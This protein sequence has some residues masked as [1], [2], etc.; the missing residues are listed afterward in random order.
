MKENN[1]KQ[2]YESIMASIAKEV[3][4]ALNEAK[5]DNFNNGEAYR[6]LKFY[7][8]KAIKMTLGETSAELAETK[9]QLLMRLK[10]G[11]SLKTVN[12]TMCYIN[13]NNVA[14][15][16]A[17]M[18]N[19]KNIAFISNNKIY[20]VD[21]NFLRTNWGNKSVCKIDPAPYRDRLG[22][23]QMLTRFNLEFLKNNASD[24]ISLTDEATAM[25]NTAYDEMSLH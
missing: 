9:N 7:A 1:K 5:T 15:S 10:I 11:K 17:K 22:E 6:F 12:L 13:Q 2:L 18:R 24:V 8:A 25:Y 3:K 14:L 21:G 20:I 4:K 16:E 19:A 23:I